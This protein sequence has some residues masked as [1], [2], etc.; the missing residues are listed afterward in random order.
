MEEEG[1]SWGLRFQ[2]IWDISDVP[3]VMDFLLVLIIRLNEL[4][5]NTR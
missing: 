1:I 3:E 4:L 5:Q 2:Q